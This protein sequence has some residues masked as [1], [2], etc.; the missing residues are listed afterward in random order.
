VFS[1]LE[2]AIQRG[3]LGPGARDVERIRVTLHESHVAS[4][5]FEDRVGASR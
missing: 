1:C 2:E 5:S 3:D 4:A